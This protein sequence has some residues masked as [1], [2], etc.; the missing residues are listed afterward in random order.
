[1]RSADSTKD[2]VSPQTIGTAGLNDTTIAASSAAHASTAHGDGDPMPP[3]EA[4]PPVIRAEASR[5]D[6]TIAVRGMKF[7]CL[8]ASC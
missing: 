1:V 5:L 8:P 4:A 2:G 3:S 7:K 6:R